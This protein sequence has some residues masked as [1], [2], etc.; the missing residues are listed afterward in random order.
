LRKQITNAGE[1]VEE[2]EPSYIL[3][4]NV[5]WSNHYGNQYGVSSQKTL[6][7][8]PS[9]LLLGIYSKEYK[10][11][12]KRDTA[13]SCYALLF[14]IVKLWNQ[15]WCPTTDKRIKKILCIYI[16]NS[17]IKCEIMPFTRK[18]MEI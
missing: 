2:K 11:I 10:S 16:N 7:H 3:S 6:P 14:T 18:E 9:L 12:Y 17:A 15:L 1:D 8:D 4:G 13:H 5:N